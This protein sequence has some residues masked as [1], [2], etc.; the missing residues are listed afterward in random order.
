[1]DVEKQQENN[2]K[3]LGGCTGKGFMP[4]VSGNPA[5]RPK[6]KTIKERVQ[7]WLDTHPDDMEGFVSHFVKVNRDLAWQMLEGRPKQDTD[8]TTLGRPIIQLPAE[9]IAKNALEANTSTEPNM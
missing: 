1:M 3:L 2:E 4:G 9:V 7:E 6:G 8:I 5:G